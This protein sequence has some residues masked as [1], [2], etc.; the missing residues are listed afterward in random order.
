MRT[1]DV[2]QALLLGT[3][4]LTF[5]CHMHPEQV[6]VE[7]KA[8][9]G[10]ADNDGSVI[11]AQEQPAIRFV[12]LRIAFALWEPEDLER[13]S[14]GITEVK[15]SNPTGSFVPLREPLRAR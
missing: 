15:G 7:L 5:S 8:R 2:V 1:E 14:I 4:V 10:I 12:P 6:T 13:M 11:D 9:L 3:I